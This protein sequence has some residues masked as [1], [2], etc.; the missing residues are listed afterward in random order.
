MA[1]NVP[2]DAGGRESRR[3]VISIHGPITVAADE[4]PRRQTAAERFA[5]VV[6]HPALFLLT[7]LLVGVVV[8]RMVI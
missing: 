6:E 7:C 3:R 8:G 1:S 4:L 5:L 2:A